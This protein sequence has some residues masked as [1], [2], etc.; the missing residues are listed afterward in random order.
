M[1]QEEMPMPEF[2]HLE[3]YLPGMAPLPEPTQEYLPME[4]SPQDENEEDIFC[5]R[6][7]VRMTRAE[8]LLSVL[9]NNADNANRTC[10]DC[11]QTQCF[12]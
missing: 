10:I 12:E 8:A 3:A 2:R 11:C 5:A 7:Q 9:G 6:A 4:V 1:N